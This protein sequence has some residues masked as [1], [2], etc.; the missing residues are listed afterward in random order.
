MKVTLEIMNL[1]TQHVMAY[2]HSRYWYAADYSTDLAPKHHQYLRVGKPNAWPK[3]TKARL[4]AGVAAMAK[5]ATDGRRATLVG[6][7]LTGQADGPT[8]D[9]LLQFA[10]F[11]EIVYG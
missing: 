11:G 9:V 10:L 2:A 1:T 3:L 4:A 7:V 8:L 5:W 6:D